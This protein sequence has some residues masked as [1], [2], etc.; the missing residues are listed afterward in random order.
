MEYGEIKLKYTYDT[1][2][3]EDGQTIDL[4]SIGI[5]C[6]DGREY[7]AENSDC[8]F[9]KVMNHNWLYQNVVPHLHTTRTDWNPGP[10][11]IDRDHVYHDLQVACVKPKW[12]I[13]NEVRDFLFGM[14]MTRSNRRVAVLP[15][16]YAYYGAFDQVVLNQLY[17]TMQQLPNGIPMFT[18]EIVTLIGANANK[19]LPAQPTDQHHALADARWNM[20][21]LRTLG[22][23]TSA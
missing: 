8:D 17:G 20:Q 2:F 12:V 1:E 10:Y 3:R 21:V 5:V 4:I 23:V 22:V 13:A 6:E 9:A 19:S 18:H 15:E 16:L 11:A 7:Y 14:T